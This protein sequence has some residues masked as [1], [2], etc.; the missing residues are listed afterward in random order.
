MRSRI[1][2]LAM[3]GAVGCSGAPEVQP[4]ESFPADPLL[5]AKTAQGSLQIEV[6]TSPAQPPGR[7]PIAVEYT[8]TDS[9]GQPRDDLDLAVVPWMPAMGHGTSTKP[10]IEARGDGRYVASG[11]SLFMPGRWELRTAI[12]GPVKDSTT[13]VL[14]IP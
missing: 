8:I 11:V 10:A 7:G 4:G 2:L 13:V 9:G 6:R 3:V 1:A 12:T 5:V 14:D